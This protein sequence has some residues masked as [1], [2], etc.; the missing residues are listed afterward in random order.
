MTQCPKCSSS[1]I[2]GPRFGHNSYGR[3]RLFYDCL[4]CGYT[5][6]ELPHDQTS[7]THFDITKLAGGN[8]F[9]YPEKKIPTTD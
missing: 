1:K 8:P 7:A 2:T 4:R 5:H 3:E 6:S 9:P